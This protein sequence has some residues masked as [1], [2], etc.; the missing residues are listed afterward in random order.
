MPIDRPRILHQRDVEGV[1]EAEID[2]A[3]LEVATISST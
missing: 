3:L 2:E 1:I